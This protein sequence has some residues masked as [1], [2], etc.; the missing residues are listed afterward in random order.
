M[1][2]RRT[3]RLNHTSNT[4]KTYKISPRIVVKQVGRRGEQGPQGSKGDTGYGMPTGG[5]TGQV[6]QKNSD[7]PFDFSWFTPSF[8]DKNYVLSFSVQSTVVVNHNL[9]KYPSV[10]VIDSAGDEVQGEVYHMNTSQLVLK[11]NA[12]FSGKVTC[13]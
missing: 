11:F 8:L 12:P 7:N 13:N 5:L 3:I 6:L 4:A 2:Q 10:T 1:A 9:N